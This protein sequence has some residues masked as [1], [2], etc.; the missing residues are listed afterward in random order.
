VSLA[1]KG[2]D[3]ALEIVA[4]GTPIHSGRLQEIN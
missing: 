1:V 4:G 3:Q 2:S